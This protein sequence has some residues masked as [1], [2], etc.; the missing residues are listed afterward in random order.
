MNKT[1]HIITGVYY[2]FNDKRLVYGGVQTY[3]SN[4]MPLFNSRG[5]Q[6]VMYQLDR[7]NAEITLPSCIVKAI[8]VSNYKTS[9]K[10]SHVALKIALQV[11]NDSTDI[12]L[13]A[14]DILNCYNHVKRSISIQHG[15]YW[16][17][18]QHENYGPQKNALYVFKKMFNAYEILK[19]CNYVKRIVCVDYNFFNWYKAVSA[20]QVI[21]MMVIPNFTEIS[22]CVNKPNDKIRIIFA[23]RLMR[24]R[25]AN[26]FADAMSVL[27]PKY[28]N[29]ELT[30]A[31]VG[32]EEDYMKRVLKTYKSQVI[33]THYNAEDSLKIHTDKH[34]AVVPT[35]GSEGT[36]LSLLEAMSAQ[37][38][39]ICTSI[40]GLSNIVIDEYNGLIVDSTI[41][42]LCGAIEKLVID[43][44]Y[45]NELACRGYDTVKYGFS[46]EKWRGKWLNVIDDVASL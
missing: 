40:G 44:K 11:F 3:L 46:Y 7:M 1:V 32:P 27:L 28:P 43:A 9:E 5:F 13:F 19:R 34:I 25:G 16:D 15:I 29:I 18:P 31:G 36:S 22:P 35:V 24:Y 42:S 45:R 30:I 17:I 23:R 6:C 2:S 12:L 14:T 8:D 4:L 20:H 21:P 33:F 39:V 37:C 41:N 38:A 26:L 10:Q